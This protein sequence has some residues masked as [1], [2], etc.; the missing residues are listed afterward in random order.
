MRKTE[1]HKI[2]KEHI[3]LEEGTCYIPDQKNQEQNQI[4]YLNSAQLKIATKRM[5][6]KGELLFDITN[7]RRRWEKVRA[8]A[9]IENIDIHCLRHTATTNVARHCKNREELKAFTRHKS[10]AGLK[11][12]LF[13]RGGRQK[14]NPRAFNKMANLINYWGR[15]GGLD[16]PYSLKGLTITLR[17][18]RT[19]L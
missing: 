18:I 9:E 5:R 15:I 13:N 16:F 7:F 19:S 3:N 12:Y 11:P 4:I 14:E 10:E 1:A 17:L 8:A 6:T 2:K